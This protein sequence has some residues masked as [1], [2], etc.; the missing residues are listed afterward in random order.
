MEIASERADRADAVRR[1]VHERRVELD[2]AEYVRM[3]TPA[4]ALI[5]RIRLDHARA[6]LDRI[7][8]AAALS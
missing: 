2:H 8:G 1:P 6:G 5:G 3:A 4:D 7:E